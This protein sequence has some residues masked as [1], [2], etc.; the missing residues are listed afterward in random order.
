M[1]VPVIYFWTPGEKRLVAFASLLACVAVLHTLLPDLHPLVV[2]LHATMPAWSALAVVGGFIA[3][4]TRCHRFVIYGYLA[5]SALHFL[6]VWAPLWMGGTPTP[7]VRSARLVVANVYVG[8]PSPQRL[9]AELKAHNPDVMLLMEVDNRWRES[10]TRTP[11]FPEYPYRLDADRDDAYGMM[12]LSRFPLRRSDVLWLD[13]VP[14]LH[15]ELRVHDRD[16]RLIGVH[17]TPPA[18]TEGLRALRRQVEPLRAWIE[19]PGAPP[20]IVAGDLNLTPWNPTFRQITRGVNLQTVQSRISEPYWPTWRPTSLL[21]MADLPILPIDHILVGE[22]VRV[23]RYTRSPGY[24][25]DH[26]A[27]VV[28]VSW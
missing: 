20:A 1:G 14:A 28:D 2:L 8:N 16:V 27:H 15:A 23:H 5:L 3:L 9:L 19:V 25:S 13:E 7:G 6:W 26:V 4:G 12:L 11:W 21:P 18:T 24:G 17:L 10:I 22:R